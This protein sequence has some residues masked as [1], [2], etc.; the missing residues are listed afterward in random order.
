MTCHKAQGGEWDNVAV[1]FSGFPGRG[2]DFYRWAYTAITRGRKTLS[3]IDPPSFGE[4]ATP[5]IF[6]KKRLMEKIDARLSD[7]DDAE[8]RRRL[9]MLL[10]S[11]DV[12]T[13]FTEHK[14]AHLLANAGAPWSKEE[15]DELIREFDAKISIAELVKKHGRTKGAINSRLV[16]LGKN[17]GFTLA[18]L[19]LRHMI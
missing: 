16:R 10:N 9:E 11:S 14:S 6:D 4:P 1:S 13:E 15:D 2:S 12:G 18:K 3:V 8:F 17:T 7:I 5:F 19:M